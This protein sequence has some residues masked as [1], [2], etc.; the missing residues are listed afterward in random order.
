MRI[1]FIGD[2]VAKAGRQL[3]S[4]VPVLI[5][6]EKIDLVVANGENAAG[7]F[8]L[9]RQVSDEIFEQDIDV[10][11]MGNHVWDR[12]EIY[13]IIDDP[14]IVRP[15]N[16]PPGV[17][18][19][20]W[21][22]IQDKKGLSV[23][24]INLSGRVFMADLDCPFRKASYVLDEIAAQTKVIIVD[25]HGE[26]TSE[27]I[28]MGWYLDGRVTAVVGTHTH[29]PTADD[30]VLPEGTAYITDVGM[31]GGIDS[32]IGVKK[33]AILK[34]FLTQMPVKMESSSDNP[35]LQ[36]VIIDADEQT[37]RAVSIKRIAIKPGA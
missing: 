25:F 10:L 13:Q 12:K 29:V 11:T 15:A 4:L 22:I 37:G 20:G 3:L 6:K 36:G 27:K 8:G 16:Y 17:P 14:R 9:T 31:T 5:N 30:R 7:G 33:E 34:R 1:L 2:I 19:H 21:T 18:G 32:V 28:A 23:A 24:V 26:A 35:V